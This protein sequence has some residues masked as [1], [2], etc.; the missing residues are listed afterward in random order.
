MLVTINELNDQAITINYL[1][2]QK[3]KKKK[4]TQWRFILARLNNNNNNNGIQVSAFY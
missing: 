3:K 4:K 1:N 2:A